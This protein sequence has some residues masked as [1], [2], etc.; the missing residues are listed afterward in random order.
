[1]LPNTEISLALGYEHVSQNQNEDEPA[2]HGMGDSE[3]SIKYRFIRETTYTPQV[4]IAPT[5]GIPTGGSDTTNEEAWLE[6]PVWIEKNW[7]NWSTSGGG[8]FVINPAD[9]AKN[10]LFGGWRLQHDFTEELNLGAEIFYQGADSVD[11][12]DL[13]LI[14]IGS[15]YKL[16]EVLSIDLSV[17]HS[18]SGQPQTIAYLGF[19]L[20]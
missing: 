19:T 13:T 12:R 18:L 20:S 7:N 14:N 4:A 10:F 15:T 11:N 1:M 2:L 17:G 6:F 16:S 9:D 8:G 5:V 3:V